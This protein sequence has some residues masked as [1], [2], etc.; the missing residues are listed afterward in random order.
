MRKFKTV[1]LEINYCDRADTDHGIRS[2]CDQLL[3]NQVKEVRTLQEI[4]K[5]TRISRQA[6]GALENS[7]FK[8]KQKKENSQM[9][10]EKKYEITEMELKMYIG[11]AMADTIPEGAAR[12]EEEKLSGFAADLCKRITS[13]LNGSEPFSETELEAY[14]TVTRIFDVVQT[15]AEVAARNTEE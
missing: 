4:K 14:R 13:H 12:E 6:W 5:S 15:L 11:L 9:A 8:Y 7:Q 1:A 2:V 3:C 10:E